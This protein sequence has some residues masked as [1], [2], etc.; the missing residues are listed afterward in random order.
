MSDPLEETISLSDM[1]EITETEGPRATQQCQGVQHVHE[2]WKELCVITLICNAKCISRIRAGM[3]IFLR[4]ET[5][6][7]S[8]K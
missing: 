5:V 7:V 6:R 3:R 1:T 4:T 8:A 2:P